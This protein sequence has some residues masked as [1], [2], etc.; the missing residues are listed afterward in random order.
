MKEENIRPANIFE[1]Y[2][3]LSAY[4]Q[5]YLIEQELISYTWIFGKKS[6]E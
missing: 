4:F 2:L 6:E 3:R 5:Q 1:K